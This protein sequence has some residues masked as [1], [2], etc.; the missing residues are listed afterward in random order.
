MAETSISLN[1]WSS[2]ELKRALDTV[3]AF[4]RQK[5]QPTELSLRVLALS[6]LHPSDLVDTRLQSDA[7]VMVP[8]KLLAQLADDIWMHNQVAAKQSSTDVVAL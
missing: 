6:K 4:C 1:V 3:L 2:E 7:V 8:S 5:D